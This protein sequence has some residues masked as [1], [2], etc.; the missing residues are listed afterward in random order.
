MEYRKT[1]HG[2]FIRLIRGEEI[3][4]KL[5]ELAEKEKIM[6]GFLFG[7]GA[8]AN[9]KL[10]YFDLGAREYRSQTFKGDYEIVNLTGNISQLD[11]KP[12]IHAHMTIS[13]EKCQALGG[14]LFSAT[15]HATGEITIID[16]GLAISRKLDEQIG[17][18]LLDL[19]T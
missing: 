13:D 19:S 15:I 5:T 18:K 7:L 14:H 11:G 4:G 6:S 10:G 9:P 8:V 16:F 2:Y 12:F 3:I 17:L 1:S